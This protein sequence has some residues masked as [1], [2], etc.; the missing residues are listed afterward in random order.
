[1]TNY[2]E[3]LDKIATDLWAKYGRPG[4]MDEFVR[5]AKAAIEAEILAKHGAE[6]G[7]MTHT[8][9][10]AIV[11]WY[12]IEKHEVYDSGCSDTAKHII[13]LFDNEL[14]EQL[15]QWLL[16]EIEGRSKL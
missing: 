5:E 14:P 12:E 13:A 7:E 10:Q 15:K 16:L 8:L 4:I 11:E 1:M 6:P 2:N 9:K 3:R